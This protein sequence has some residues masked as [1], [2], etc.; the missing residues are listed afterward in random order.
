M[1]SFNT[2]Q[3]PAS[4]D[5]VEKLAVWASVTLNYLYFDEFVTESR[6]SNVRV[7]QSAPFNIT[8]TDPI[9]WRQ[10]SRQSIELNPDWVS[11]G[12]LWEFAKPI[13]NSTIPSDFQS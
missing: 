7:A 1:T 5:T 6:N 2:S 11:S 8:A 12:K 10:I 13:G 9:Q 3:L 4:I